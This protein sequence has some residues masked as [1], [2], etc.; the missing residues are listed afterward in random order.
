MVEL[1]FLGLFW[2]YEGSD[3]QS[4]FAALSDISKASGEVALVR[5]MLE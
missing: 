1:E 3:N 2:K 5:G 4:F